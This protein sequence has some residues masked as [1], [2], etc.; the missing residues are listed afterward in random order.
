[1]TTKHEEEKLMHVNEKEDS[2]FHNLN[3]LEITNNKYHDSSRKLSLEYK[4][5]QKELE[6]LTNN[7]S[8][9]SLLFTIDENIS[10]KAG[11]YDMI[12]GLRLGF[13]PK[14]DLYWEEIN[15]SWSLAAQFLMFVGGKTIHLFIFF[16]WCID[17]SLR[18]HRKI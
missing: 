18:A 8:L 13:R 6:L 15:S 14:K 5:S 11:R 7:V 2:F 9:R 1:M 4:S 16:K 17:P 10:S 3:S 12:N